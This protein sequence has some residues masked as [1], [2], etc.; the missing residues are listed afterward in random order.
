[1]IIA[2][3]RVNEGSVFLSNV[4]MNPLIEPAG[5]AFGSFVAIGTSAGGPTALKKILTP[6]PH[7]WP[8]ALLIVQHMPAGFTGSLAKRLNALA[9]IEV[10][11]AREGDVVQPGVAYIAPGGRHMKCIF[12]GTDHMQIQLCDCA[13]VNSHRPS[14]DVLFTSLADLKLPD[15][16]AIILTGMG[17]DGAKG[18]DALKDQGALIIVEDPKTA[19]IG[20][21]SNAAIRTNCVDEILNIDQIGQRL[22]GVFKGGR[23]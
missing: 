8:A 10:V 20:G 12:D 7:N 16:I 13:P 14:I 21:M 5:T 19:L 11:E 2:K 4:L 22:R 6:L 17:S 18:V 23:G 9:Q 15:I 1:M 3:T